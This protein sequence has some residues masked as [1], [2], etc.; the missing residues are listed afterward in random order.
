MAE[1]GKLEKML[2]LA[3]ESSEDAEYGGAMDAKDSFEALINP[4]TYT[5]SYKVKTK[6]GQGQGTSGAQ[7]KFEYT[8]PEELTFE[9]LFDNTG[10]IDGMPKKEG[11]FDDVDHFR[12]ILTEYQGKSHEPHHL[13]LVWGNLIFKGRAVELDITYKLFNPDGQPIRAAAKVKFKGS[14]EEKK[15]AAKENRSSPDLTHRKKIKAGD[16]LPL[17]C[18]RVYGDPRYYLTV[19]KV[20]GLNH[21]QALTPGTD[22]IFPPIDKTGKLS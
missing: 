12:R 22:L 3:F 9:F 21:F 6:D 15:R 20:N 10:V 13:K 5:L 2:I 18:Y 19:A 14:I 16:T 11:V 8:M 7:A 17:M 4:E 1:S